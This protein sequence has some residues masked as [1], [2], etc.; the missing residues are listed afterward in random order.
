M[1]WPLSDQTLNLRSQRLL[2]AVVL[3]VLSLVSLMMAPGGQLAVPTSDTL[4]IVQELRLPRLLL[5]IL[6]G[7]SLG[8]AG[9]ALQGYSHNPLAD[10][11]LLGINSWAALGAVIAFYF[12]PVAVL[13][14]WMPL[15]GMIGAGVGLLALALIGRRQLSM[16]SFILTGVALTAL[17]SSLTSLALNLAPNPFA[18]MELIY[19]LMGSTTDKGLSQVLLITP[20]VLVGWI[21]LLST[22]KALHAW[23]LGQSVARTLGVK[24]ATLHRKLLL[25]CGLCVGASIAMTGAIAFVGLAVPHLLRPWVRGRADH[26]LWHSTLGGALLLVAADLICKIASSTTELRL[27]VVTA[28]LGSP[29]LF[30][31]LYR[32][33]GG[34]Q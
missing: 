6:C 10:A 14:W 12:G 3:L 11:G 5:T 24:P 19:W 34:L 7:G 28:L 2:L 23:S 22:G 18:A 13:A 4:S 16:T 25:G 20:F 17:A 33:R 9:A 30:M 21:I 32:Q 31:L 8:L 29:F 27:G 26:L 1:K 15:G